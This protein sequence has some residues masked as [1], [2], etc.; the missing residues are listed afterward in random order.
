VR[1][2]L[3]YALDRELVAEL[4][5]G[6]PLALP[7]CHH[8]APG[9]PGYAPECDYTRDPRHGGGIWTGPDLERA[10]ALIERSRTAGRQ[11]TVSVSDD[12]LRVG[13]YVARLLKQLGYR[14][15]LRGRGEY[16][17]YHSYVAD[18]RN[19]AQI[20][21]DGW[22]ADFPTPTDF[23][24]PFT[25]ANYRARSP[26]NSNLSGYC[27]KQFER[28]I[29][30]ALSARGADADALWHGAYRYLARSAPAAPLVNRRGAVFVS[31]RLGNYQHHP[32]FGVLLDQVW[33][34]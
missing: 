4:E 28:R 29:D 19:G 9:H 24:T 1:R 8:V 14:T 10:H 26:E 16:G 13:R 32:L 17:H 34:R 31:E 5:G 20:G 11:V 3:N 18:S 33:V 27:N 12:K 6:D 21:T 2:A 22:A 7:A 25:C 30:A 23:T 15:R